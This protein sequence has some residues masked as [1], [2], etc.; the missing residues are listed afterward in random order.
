[1]EGIISFHIIFLWL[2]LI[3][4]HKY[5]KN[6][7]KSWFIKACRALV[8]LIAGGPSIVSRSILLYR[9]NADAVFFLRSISS[10]LFLTPPTKYIFLSGL[11][12]RKLYIDVTG[13]GVGDISIDMFF[14][15]S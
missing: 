11:V 14:G 2:L 12:F 10:C 4:S 9:F 3:S 1:L 5:E 7:L 8:P 13:D 6:K 15:R